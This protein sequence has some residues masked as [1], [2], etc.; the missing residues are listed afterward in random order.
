MGDILDLDDIHVEFAPDLVNMALDPATG[1]DARISNMRRHVASAFG[2][3]L[4]EVRLTD[5]PALPPGKYRIRIHGVDHAE[6]LLRPE[7]VLA[8]MPPEGSTALAG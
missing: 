1:L 5:N 8:L 2:L 6:D 7:Q 3:V 4:P